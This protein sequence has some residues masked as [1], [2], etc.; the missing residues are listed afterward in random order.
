MRSER[1]WG[2]LRAAPWGATIGAWDSI[3]PGSSSDGRTVPG[4]D[5]YLVRCV[6]RLRGNVGCGG[7]GV[8]RQQLD[9][10]F[11]DP[12]A[13]TLT[14]TESDAG[15]FDDHDHLEWCV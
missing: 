1:R 7:A 8:R 10:R 13:L 12:I 14:D 2:R 9:A 15:D 3:F 4:T 11:A 5:T 6:V